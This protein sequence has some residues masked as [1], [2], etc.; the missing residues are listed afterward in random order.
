MMAAGGDARLAFDGVACLRGHR[1]LFE[2]LS[3]ALGPG[4][5]ALITGPN[6]TGKSSLL[7]MA[8]GLLAPAAGAIHREGT[9][10][11]ADERHALDPLKPLGEA[12]GF[13]AGV[14]GQGRDAVAAGLDAVG[15]GA[16]AEVPV[17]M[18]STGQARRAGLARLIAGRAH[19][20]LLDEP[21][22]G[23]DAASLDRLAATMAA[24][25]A[26]G[27]IILAASHQPLGLDDAQPIRFRA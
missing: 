19:I 25:R 18:L 26:Q 6:G 1:L 11:L 15:L 20:W 7:R 23:L 17:R 21:G 9:I 8:A 16:I 14:D 2:G 10:A 24:H 4:D 13:W 27:G 22:N 5:A 3:F 12:L